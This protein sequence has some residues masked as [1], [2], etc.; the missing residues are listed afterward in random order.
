[1]NNCYIFGEND[2]SCINSKIE[3]EEMKCYYSDADINVTEKEFD[4]AED[5]HA[6]DCRT[7]TDPS[8]GSAISA[9]K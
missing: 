7:Q 2:D 6:A 3:A 9:A 1:M 4:N 5:N 8:P